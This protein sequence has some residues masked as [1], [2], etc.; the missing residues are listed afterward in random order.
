MN[1]RHT[2]ETQQ[3]PCIMEECL[4]VNWN[5]DSSHS[6]TACYTYVSPNMSLHHGFSKKIGSEQVPKSTIAALGKMPGS[7]L[8]NMLAISN[9][10]I[11]MAVPTQIKAKA[12]ATVILVAVLLTCSPALS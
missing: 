5:S 4:H 1:N 7:W 12:A 3:V 10:G 8:L 2:A 11:A 6:F 9:A